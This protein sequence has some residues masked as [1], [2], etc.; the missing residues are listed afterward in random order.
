MSFAVAADAYDRFMGR[1]SFPL[2]S[3]FADFASITSGQRVLD[4][5]CGTGAL[6]A[7]LVGRLGAGHVAAVEPS[8]TF[9]ASM[10]ERFSDVDVRQAPAERV[11]FGGGEFDAALAQLVV[12]FMVD[13]VAG[14]REMTRI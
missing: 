7:E 2:A 8:P 1:F 3:V 6:T 10:Q 14:L 9:F 5:G 12:H 11:P 13:P 4:V